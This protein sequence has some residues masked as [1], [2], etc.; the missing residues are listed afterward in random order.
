[1]N[2]RPISPQAAQSPDSSPLG[3]TA[4]RRPAATMPSSLRLLVALTGAFLVVVAPRTSHSQSSSTVFSQFGCDQRPPQAAAP[5]PVGGSSFVSLGAPEQQVESVYGSPVAKVPGAPGTNMD[6]MKTYRYE[7]FQI[8]AFYR[9]QSLK[10]EVFFR[11]AM[12]HP[13]EIND[14]LSSSSDGQTWAICGTHTEPAMVRADGAV[15]AKHS[16][17]KGEITLVDLRQ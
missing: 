3:G 1:V 7:G 9:G 4:R 8:K 10:A 5:E 15:V 6:Y 16:I 17:F 12:L 13:G 14:I 2:R 11:G